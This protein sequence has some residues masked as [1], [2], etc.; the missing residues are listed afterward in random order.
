VVTDDVHG[1][2]L[3]P[4]RSA[5]GRPL[6][7]HL[8][9]TASVT[10]SGITFPPSLPQR[11]WETLG[12]QLS[13]VSN[14]SAWWLADWLVYGETAYSGRYREAVERTGLDY[15]TLRNYAWVARRFDQERR[16][17]NL[18]L[19]HHAEVA[20]LTPPEQDYWLRKAERGEWSRNRLRKEVRASLVERREVTTAVAGDGAGPGDRGIVTAGGVT[21]DGHLAAIEVELGPEQL[22]RC[23]RAAVSCGLSLNDWAARVLQL[24]VDAGGWPRLALDVSASDDDGRLDGSRQPPSDGPQRDDD[25]V[26]A[27][28]ERA[29]QRCEGS[30]R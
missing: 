22:D 10:R 11:A 26:A 28:P 23:V 17:D 29:A 15:Q 20:R 6:L 13:E 2:S 12:V 7:I 16:H 5:D 4:D 30:A 18:S 21:P 27:Q 25:V 1:K 19:A 14:S 9:G 3:Q 8:P 24:A